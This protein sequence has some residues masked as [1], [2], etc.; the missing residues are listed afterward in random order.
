MSKTIAKSLIIGSLIIFV[1]NIIYV[2]LN[3]PPDGRWVSQLSITSIF[4]IAYILI[5]YFITKKITFDNKNQYFVILLHTIVAVSFF[6]IGSTIE[7]S[8]QNIDLF[9]ISQWVS[10]APYIIIYSVGLVL[11]VAMS[12]IFQI[13]TSY[14]PKKLW[15]RGGIIAVIVCVGLFLFYSCIYFPIIN[16][17]YVEDIA[18]YGGTPEWT[19]TI[20]LVTGHFF[21]LLSGFIVPHGFL[22]EFT[23]PVCTNW[24][25][26][27]ATGSVLWTM[28]GQAGYCL[29]QTMTPTDSCAK[30]SEIVGFLGL[31]TLLVG[32][33]FVIGAGIGIFIQKRKAK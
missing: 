2:F 22:C 7:R 17:L 6:V 19:T 13:K 31:T 24:S 25:S 5:V 11:Y 15:L 1:A 23:E 16:N 10:I 32:V 30:L 27:N 26:E 20:P 12:K 18:S 29:E 21:P 4:T 9:Y 33:Y 28:E 8:F 14:F 3:V